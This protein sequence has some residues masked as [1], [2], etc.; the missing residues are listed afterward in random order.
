VRSKKIGSN[1]WAYLELADLDDA[2]YYASR[3]GFGRA[4]CTSRGDDAQSSSVVSIDAP[5]IHDLRIMVTY[6]FRA[7]SKCRP[8]IR[9]WLLQHSEGRE[10]EASDQGHDAALPLIRRA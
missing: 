9:V 2:A 8:I 6:R 4:A 3:S 10:S 1:D 5:A 7:A